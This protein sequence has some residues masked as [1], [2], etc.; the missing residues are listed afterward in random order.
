MLKTKAKYENIILLFI[1]EMHHLSDSRERIINALVTV[2][3]T[4][5][6]E[7][8]LSENYNKFYFIES[9]SIRHNNNKN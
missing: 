8:N 9:D 2:K 1:S 5:A 7:N 6:I 4:V 3:V